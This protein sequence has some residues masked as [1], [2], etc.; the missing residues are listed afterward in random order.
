MKTDKYKDWE[1]KFFEGEELSP[2]EER[3]LKQESDDPYFSFLREEKQE[4]MKL[5]FDDFL[6][7][8]EGEQV[9]PKMEQTSIMP[10]GSAK[11]KFGN[12][13]KNYWMAASLVMFMGVLGGYLFVNQESG[14]VNKPLQPVVKQDA[15]ATVEQQSQILAQKN[16]EDNANVAQQNV[17]KRLAQKPELPTS[18]TKNMVSVSQT[19]IHNLV[20]TETDNVNYQ[21]AYN[22]NYVVINGK[23][24][25]NEQEAIALTED[26]VNYLAS[27]VSQTVDHAQNAT[28]LSLDLK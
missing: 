28:S 8:V 5:D 22:P 13:F 7:K 10:L 4:K 21:E 14:D 24:V 6:S 2:E 16:I 19:E 1:Y 20:E 27:N 17:A 12:G 18:K 23:P 26:A 15:E 11:P 3:L 25:Y 9:A